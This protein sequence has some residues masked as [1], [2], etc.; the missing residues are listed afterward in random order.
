MLRLNP[1]LAWRAFDDEIVAYHEAS[2]NSFLVSGM[3]ARILAGLSGG[4]VARLALARRFCPDDAADPPTDAAEVFEA[5]LAFL[6][7]L[8]AV[9]HDPSD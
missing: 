2:G 5:S 8:E 3:A 1:D 4:P 9:Q 6:E 7:E